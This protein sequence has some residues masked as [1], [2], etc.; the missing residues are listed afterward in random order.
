MS[1]IALG[2]IAGALFGA[3]AG[4]YITRKKYAPDPIEADPSFQF[5]SAVFNPPD[6]IPPA[7]PGTC[8]GLSP[9]GRVAFYSNYYNWCAEGEGAVPVL[10][11]R[12][13]PAIFLA[14]SNKQL[15]N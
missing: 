12:D 3:A 14:V 10:K 7:D 15:S 11:H 6:H 4:V 2:F 13:R 8:G 9:T 1:G 5:V